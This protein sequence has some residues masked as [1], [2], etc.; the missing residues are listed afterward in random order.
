VPL[1]SSDCEA[2]KRALEGKG[3]GYRYSDVARWLRRAGFEPP[4]KTEGSH[5]VW[6]HAMH[7]RVQLVEKGHGELLP[8]YVKNAARI[9]LEMEICQ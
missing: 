6:V 5:R 7:R 4:R 2:I 3:T 8:A 1:S 9:L